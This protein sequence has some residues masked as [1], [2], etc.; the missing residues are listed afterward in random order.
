[1]IKNTVSEANAEKEKEE[2]WFNDQIKEH[3]NTINLDIEISHLII[4]CLYALSNGMKYFEMVE[5][6]KK[7]QKTLSREKLI[8]VTE[9]KLLSEVKY[10]SIYP[11]EEID[12][13]FKYMEEHSFARVYDIQIDDKPLKLLGYVFS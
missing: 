2:K 11:P 3:I 12:R 10:K 1:M 7:H 4:R 5:Y 13:V 6:Q 9:E 8:P